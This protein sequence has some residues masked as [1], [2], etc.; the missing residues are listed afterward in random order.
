MG[1][2]RDGREF[3]AAIN[4]GSLFI[5]PR[6]INDEVKQYLGVRTG[7]DGTRSLTL[8][9]DNIRPVCNN[10]VTAA[11]ASAKRYGASRYVSMRHTTN[12]LDRANA[13]AMGLAAAR[14]WQ[15]AFA[16][17]AERLLAANGGHAVL[18]KVLDHVFGAPDPDASKR[19]VTMATERREAVHRLYDG[20]TN[21]GGFGHNG[22]TVFNALGEYLDHA[23]RGNADQRAYASMTPSSWV[24]AAKVKARELLLDRV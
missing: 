5:D 18:D 2:M 6:G 24:D 19:S 16:A 1:V 13:A 3:F 8:F 10:T 9:N 4:L 17:T 23:R 22:W 14:A 15:E 7:H 11:V 21:A 20:P 12:V